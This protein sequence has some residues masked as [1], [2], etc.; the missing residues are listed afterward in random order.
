M[1]KSWIACSGRKASV[2]LSSSFR[3]VTLGCQYASVVEF[4]GPHE[5]G[6]QRGGYIAAH[7]GDHDNFNNA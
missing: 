1:V 3:T 7:P 4:V 2:G 6:A 5:G